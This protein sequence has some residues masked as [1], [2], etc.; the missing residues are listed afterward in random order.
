MEANRL[1]DFYGAYETS[2][3]VSII[4]DRLS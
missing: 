1:T 3:M 2:V 4:Y